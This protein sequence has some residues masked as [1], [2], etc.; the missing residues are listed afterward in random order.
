MDPIQDKSIPKVTEPLKNMQSHLILSDIPLNFS[1]RN[2]V[3]NSPY[4]QFWICDPLIPG[5]HWC[6]LLSKVYLIISWVWPLELIVRSY[7][8]SPGL[9]TSRT[10][11][12]N[13]LN[14][15]PGADLAFQWGVGGGGL[16]FYWS[17]HCIRQVSA[18]CSNLVRSSCSFFWSALVLMSR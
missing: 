3:W 4:S 11:H 17:R 6:W 15:I 8:F 14:F 5:S 12:L 7:L 13:G 1:S 9:C 10:E 2:P 18:Q 16:K